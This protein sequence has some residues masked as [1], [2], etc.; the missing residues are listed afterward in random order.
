LRKIATGIALL[1]LV[2]LVVPGLASAQMR[3]FRGKVDAINKKEVMVDNRMG[4]KLKFKPAP[5]V[6]VEGEKDSWAKLKKNDWVVVS[7]KMMD[8]PRI[9]YKVVVLPPQ[10]EAGEDVE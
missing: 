7:W 6:A 5:D 3:E 9:A 1:A 10:D 4:D 2:A 8:N